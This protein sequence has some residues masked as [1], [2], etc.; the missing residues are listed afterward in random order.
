MGSEPL[1]NSQ[2]DVEAFWGFCKQHKIELDLVPS[3]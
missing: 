2:K 1:L 3:G